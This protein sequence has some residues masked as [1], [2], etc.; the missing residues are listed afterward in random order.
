MYCQPCIDAKSRNVD[1]TSSFTD[2]STSFHKNSLVAHDV[3]EKH[4]KSVLMQEAARAK[5]GTTISEKSLEKMCHHTFKQMC[6]LFRNAHALAKKG[7]PFTDFVWMAELDKK[8]DVNIGTDYINDKQAAT[9]CHFIAEIEMKKLRDIFERAKFISL[10][11]DG[12]T[13][14]ASIEAEILY[15][16]SVIDGV[17]NVKFIC[18]RNV[19]KADAE[20]ITRT[21]DQAMKLYVDDDWKKKLVGM[22]TDGASVMRGKVGGVVSRMKTLA[23]AEVMIGIHCC[24]HRLELAYKII[25]EVKLFKKLEIVLTGLYYLYRNSSLCRSGL[26]ISYRSLDPKGRILFPTRVGGTRFVGHHLRAVTN[27]M[28]GWPAIIQHLQQV[29]KTKILSFFVKQVELS[30]DMNEYLIN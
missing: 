22:G 18:V 11:S 2:G 23:N 10:I 12:S 5:P 26:I 29:S 4:K 9:F 21:I 13:D 20:T 27:L 24:G 6:H 28:N 1:V 3:S 19:S 8:K 16:R 14:S 15:M 17:V 25:K 30:P 7:R